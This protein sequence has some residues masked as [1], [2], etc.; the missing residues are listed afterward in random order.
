MK[1]SQEELYV[2]HIRTY[3]EF[4]VACNIDC[5]D[6]QRLVFISLISTVSQQYLPTVS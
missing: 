3:K 2:L 1:T 4:T 6:V 5:G